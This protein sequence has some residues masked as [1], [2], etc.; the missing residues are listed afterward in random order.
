MKT[1]FSTQLFI[2]GIIIWCV[3]EGDFQMVCISF[4]S[5]QFSRFNWNCVR[6]IS[7][8]MVLINSFRGTGIF[9]SHYQNDTYQGDK[10]KPFKRMMFL[11]LAN[12]TR[13]SFG[14]GMHEESCTAAVKVSNVLLRYRPLVSRS[15]RSW[16]MWCWKWTIMFQQLPFLTDL[17][18]EVLPRKARKRSIHHW[19]KFGCHHRVVSIEAAIVYPFN[20][21]KANSGSVLKM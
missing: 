13:L 11:K 21:L 20:V 18:K 8:Q 19:K 7:L 9:L 6:F 12:E 14:Q 2:E 4:L 17:S 10:Q 3:A 1:K 5:Q 16:R 15:K